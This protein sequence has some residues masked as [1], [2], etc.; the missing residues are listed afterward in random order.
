MGN[1]NKDWISYNHTMSTAAHTRIS[2]KLY[3]HMRMKRKKICWRMNIY[4]A[5]NTKK[6]QN[7][8][9]FPFS[10]TLNF[11]WIPS[12]FLICIHLHIFF[13]YIETKKNELHHNPV[14][15]A[16][17]TQQNAKELEQ[18]VKKLLKKRKE[19]QKKKERKDEIIFHC[20]ECVCVCAS[21]DSVLHI[22]TLIFPDLFGVTM[23]YGL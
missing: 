7:F 19:E 10:L 11:V 17:A 8:F 2:L 5:F 4:I 18:F 13:K 3:I 9:C 12:F 15:E 16:G 23:I 6:N 21:I 1:S 14:V 22:F 20:H